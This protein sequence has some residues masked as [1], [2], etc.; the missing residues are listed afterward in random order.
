MT[1]KNSFK[2]KSKTMKKR[3][4]SL[5]VLM[6][7][8]ASSCSPDNKKGDWD[9]NDYYTGKDTVIKNQTYR[10]SGL[11]Y[12]YLF[13]NNSVTRYYPN[14]G[15][16]ET[17]PATSHRDGVFLNSPNHVNNG[18]VSATSNTFTSSR[19]GGFGTTSRGGYYSPIS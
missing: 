1:S 2:P 11:G 16:T 17:L 9:G 18:G 6:A 14:T 10:R 7:I 8:I 3:K 12:W 13:N 4:V 19:G 15:F 5:A